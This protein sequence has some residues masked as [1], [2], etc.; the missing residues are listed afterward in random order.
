MLV[1]DMCRCLWESRL[2]EAGIAVVA[3]GVSRA[4]AD[5]SSQIGG[6]GGTSASRISSAH[7]ARQV[8]Q[9]RLLK[10]RRVPLL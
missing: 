2:A 6:H 1:L 5:I 8:R 3:S 7:G 4:N 9:H 10:R